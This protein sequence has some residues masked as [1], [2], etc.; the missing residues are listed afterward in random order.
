MIHCPKCQSLFDPKTKWGFKKFCSRSCGNSRVRTEEFK[1][2]ARE[3]SLA[4]PKGWAT[5]PT[6]INGAKASKEKWN[7]LRQTLRCK[8]CQKQFEVP[9]SQRN[10]KYCSIDCANKNKYHV[11][12]NRKKTCV[13]RGYKMDSGAE[14]VFAQQCDLH[15]IRWHK[16]TTQYFVFV[17]S[18]G[19]TSKYYPD[20]YLEQ[21][22]IW[23]EIKGRCY[24][25]PDDELRRGAVGKPVFLII[26]N[27]FSKDFAKFKEF[28][29]L[30]RP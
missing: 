12:S 17:D 29:G 15:Q 21:Y 26:S 7:A 6:N 9:Y 2:K 1:Q 24:I 18:A 8:E 14:L 30:V 3:F 16:N 20:F 19:K 5:N 22:D 28:I 13:Y 23:V 11:N 25:R 27:Q 4:N 10:R